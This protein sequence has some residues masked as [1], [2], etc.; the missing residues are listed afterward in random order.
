VLGQLS[1]SSGLVVNSGNF[2]LPAEMLANGAPST[3]TIGTGAT[4]T[5]GSVTHTG[6]LTLQRQTDGTYAPAAASIVVNSSTTSATIQIANPTVSA[7]VTTT[8]TSGTSNLTL[9]S[10]SGLNLI[11]F[12]TLP[13]LDPGLLS[14]DP[15]LFF[16]GGSSVPLEPYTS[17]NSPPLALPAA[18]AEVGTTLVPCEFGGFM[19]SPTGEPGSWGLLPAPP[20]DLAD[21]VDIAAHEHGVIALRAYTSP[22]IVLQPESQEV[23]A[24]YSGP[25]FRAQ[26]AGFPAPALQWQK[27]TQPVAGQ[28]QAVLT[29]TQASAADAGSYQLIATNAFGRAASDAA[30]L[31]VTAPAFFPAWTGQNFAP[32]AIAAGHDAPQADPGGRG[33]PNYLR[34]A[35]GLDPANPDSAELPR[36]AF[37]RHPTLPANVGGLFFCVPENLAD[38]VFRLGVSTNLGVWK[39][40]DVQPV[41]GPV[42]NGKRQVWLP[43]PPDEQ[44]VGKTF[45]KLIIESAPPS[46]TPRF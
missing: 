37:G 26:A 40:L 5:I 23:F 31:T 35:L 43:C 22:R 2:T 34:Y 7:V 21:I 12:T 1:T 10:T 30:V 38:V 39:V 4:V 42:A 36:L 11:D 33:I 29:L 9:S 27:G 25:A 3:I 28:T 46:M 16:G 17:Y 19:L 8:T 15:S 41:L 32:S 24:G 14:W 13:T 6:P 45:Y 18:S 20:A 44:D